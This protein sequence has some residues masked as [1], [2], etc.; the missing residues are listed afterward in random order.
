VRIKVT[1]RQ[2]LDDGT[3]A[4]LDSEPAAAL[5]DSAEQFAGLAGWAGDEVPGPRRAR[6]GAHG[7]GPR[8]AAP[9]AVG[10][11]QARCRAGGAGGGCHERRRRP[12]RHPRTRLPAGTGDRV[13]AG[14]GDADGLPEPAGAEPI[15]RRRAAGPSLGPVLDGD[16]GMRGCGRWPPGTWPPAAASRPRTTSRPGPA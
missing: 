3:E 12:A 15:S 1:F 16:A 10:H 9:A 2:V 7:R 14:H 4:G 13:R 8:A 6:E 5:E 11:V